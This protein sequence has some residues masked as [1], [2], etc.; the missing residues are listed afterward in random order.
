[1]SRQ[2]VFPV[3]IASALTFIATVALLTLFNRTRPA[4]IV[5]QPA[6]PVVTPAPTGTP[7]F[8]TVYVNGAVRQPGLYTLS[9]E[10][11]AADALEAAGGAAP[12][13]FTDS[14]NLAAPL[15]DGVQ[16]YVPSQEQA[17]EL[18]TQLLAAPVR[19]PVLI[20]ISA[21]TP[22]GSLIDLNRAGQAELE[23]LPGV[24]PATARA[25]IAH[26]EEKG[27]FRTIEDVMQ[28]SGIGPAKFE[29]MRSFITTSQP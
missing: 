25:I 10:S 19:S 18:V 5:I 27:L 13:A 9:A 2:T 6:A 16:L 12:H 26:R 20:D 21:D 4:P 22:S 29:Q 7:A 24:G 15:S 11:R 23:T 14:L 3:A 8:L 1:M 28:V 17:A